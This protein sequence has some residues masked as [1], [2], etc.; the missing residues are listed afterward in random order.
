[1]ELKSFES[2]DLFNEHINSLQNGLDNGM[3]ITDKM[4]TAEKSG[5]LYRI[6][7]AF[8][9][10][11]GV[12]LTHTKVD[13]VAKAAFELAV[14]N[15]QYLDSDNAALLEGILSQIDQLTEERYH[16][17][18]H[19]AIEAIKQ[20]TIGAPLSPSSPGSSPEIKLPPPP[21]PPAP[22]LGNRPLNANA[23]WGKLLEEIQGGAA[24]KKV[25]GQG[26][27][28]SDE[29]I[30]AHERLA[31]AAAAKRSNLRHVEREEKNE[32][33]KPPEWAVKQRK[34]IGAES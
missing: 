6:L 9:R 20:Q 15:R 28:S 19:L 26:E 3:W 25:G 8:L 33:S 24:L 32:E 31:R 34:K 12:D 22:K 4:E 21:P 5:R 1:M 10:L 7:T 23:N 14:E 17:D 29:G 2:K 18:I 16:G 27:G 13:C 30:P 11:F